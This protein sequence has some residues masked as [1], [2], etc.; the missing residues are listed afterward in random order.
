MAEDPIEL[1]RRLRKR[2]NVVRFVTLAPTYLVLRAQ[3]LNPIEPD[4][5]DLTISKRC[6]ERAV[7]DWRNLLLELCT[8][9]GIAKSPDVDD[10]DTGKDGY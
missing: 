7:Q 4:P 2:H 5:A 6:W 1:E 10:A 3:G 8:R 9:H